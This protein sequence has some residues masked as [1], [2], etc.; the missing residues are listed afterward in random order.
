MNEMMNRPTSSGIQLNAPSAANSVAMVFQTREMVETLGMMQMAKMNPRDYEVIRARL[1]SAAQNE[2][3]AVAAEYIYAKGGTEVTGLSIRAA[4]ALARAYGNIV[5][6]CREVEVTDKMTKCQAYCWDMETNSR[7]EEVFEVPH[8]RSKG[9][10]DEHG[11]RIGTEVVPITDQRE[12]DEI[13]RSRG[14]RIKRACILAAIPVD[15]QEE[16]ADECDK[17]LS[18]KL[19]KM[20]DKKAEAKDGEEVYTIKDMIDDMLTTLSSK[21]SV[22]KRMVCDRFQKKSENDLYN[23]DNRQ[24]VML[25]RIM[26]GLKDG[27]ATPADYFKGASNERAVVMVGA[28]GSTG[29]SKTVVKAALEAAN[30]ARA[31]GPSGATKPDPAKSPAQSVRKAPV[32]APAATSAKPAGQS[33]VDKLN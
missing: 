1:H 11:R 4:E 2:N 30:A 9:K 13:T 7:F 27:I 3:L 23:L 26:A 18:R 16:F 8:S 14:A 32:A 20:V 21:Y 15:I 12:L 19:R 17:T 5:S 29:G 31:N 25:L 24:V 10:W 22:S 6:G 28:T 33:G